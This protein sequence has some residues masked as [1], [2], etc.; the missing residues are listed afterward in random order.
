VAYL[1]TVLRHLW[2]FQIAAE[3][4]QFQLAADRLNIVQSAVSRRIRSLEDELGVALFERRPNGA[5]LTPEGEILRDD[6]AR[7]FQL[8]EESIGRVRRA[9]VGHVGS[10]RV[11]F[12]ELAMRHSVLSSAIR[13]FGEKYVEVELKL[14]PMISHEQERALRAEEIDIGVFHR[15]GPALDELEYRHIT[16]HHLLLALPRGHRAARAGEVR[17]A[18]LGG[19]AFVFPGR[20]H[21]PRVHDA[22]LS[23]FRLAGAYP[24]IVMEVGT[25]ETMLRMVEAGIGL[26]FVDSS[27]LGSEP[28][29][30]VLKPM[31]DFKVDL[32]LE[33]VWRKANRS[34]VVRHFVE[35]VEALC[36][37]P[38]RDAAR[39]ARG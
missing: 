14:T 1:P 9:S 15:N 2:A 20:V 36:P 18:D 24:R 29:G 34:P 23:T 27:R 13:Q 12:I 21:S 7:V 38:P 11:G 33:L 26:G 37:P 30:V 17:L 28:K 31:S 16:T 8:L 22:L 19:E 10:L 32:Q 3:E 25:S 6:V 5:K 39:R 35:L 4:E